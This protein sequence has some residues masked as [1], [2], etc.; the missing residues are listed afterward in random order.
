MIALS[1][2]MHIDETAWKSLEDDMDIR[3]L[4]SYIRK[5]VGKKLF[6]EGKKNFIDYLQQTTIY[7]ADKRK[8]LGM[9]TINGFFEDQNYP[10]YVLSFKETQRNENRNK[11]YWVIL[12]KDESEMPKK[13]KKHKKNES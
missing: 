5:L 11:N 13:R 7:F 6:S 8:T 4:D 2:L 12:A 9:K 1:R 10:Y 3:S